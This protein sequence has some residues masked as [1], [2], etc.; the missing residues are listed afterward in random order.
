VRVQR[1]CAQRAAAC[2]RA[3]LCPCARAHLCVQNV[4]RAHVRKVV[5]VC[6]QVG[7]DPMDVSHVIVT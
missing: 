4:V 2:A 5:C 6:V 3:H 1:G 7:R